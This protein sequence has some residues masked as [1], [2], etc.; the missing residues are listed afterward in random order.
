MKGGA[1]PL[2]E[3]MRDVYRSQPTLQD[4]AVLISGFMRQPRLF[5]RWMRTLALTPSLRRM[6][7]RCPRLGIKVFRPYVSRRLSCAERQEILVTHYRF[8]QRAG[9]SDLVERAVEVPQT[10]CTIVGKNDSAYGLELHGNA[11]RCREGESLLYLR[12]QGSVLYRAAFTLISDDGHPAIHIGAVQ[13]LRSDDAADAVR[14][15]TRDLYGCRPKNLLVSALRALGNDFGCDRCIGIADANRVLAKGAQNL[16]DGQYD[17][18]W[19]EIGATRRTD[20][21]FMMPCTNILDTSLA[22]VPSKKRAEVKRKLTLL[23]DVFRMIRAE[24]QRQRVGHTAQTGADAL[25]DR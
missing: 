22:D 17:A 10:L 18:M 3:W 6:A 7:Q 8:W 24:L 11:L 20:G 13:G 12:A 25:S 1:M 14:R 23:E 5:L 4:K 9:L 2:F 15:A 19:S 16:G 21:D